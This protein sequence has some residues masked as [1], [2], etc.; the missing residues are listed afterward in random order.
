MWQIALK[1][2]NHYQIINGNMIYCD[3]TTATDA[4]NNVST[5]VLFGNAEYILLEY[6][7]FKVYRLE[8]GKLINI[9]TRKEKV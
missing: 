4:L 7:P 5:N 1:Y 9:T 3:K 6:S 8:N 2:K